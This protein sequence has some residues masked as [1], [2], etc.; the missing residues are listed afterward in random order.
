MLGNRCR[1]RTH[2]TQQTD[3]NEMGGLH[4][5]TTVQSADGLLFDSRKDDFVTYQAQDVSPLDMKKKQT[6]KR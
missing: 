2:W 4:T 6:M 5:E 1:Q 3:V